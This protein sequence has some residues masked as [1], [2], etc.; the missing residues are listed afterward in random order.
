MITSPGTYCIPE[1][2]YH[3][4]PCPAPSLS[5]S[6]AKVL[7]R[8]SPLHAKMM[9]PKL[10]PNY[11]SP[12]SSRFDLGTMAHAMLLEGD[13]SKLVVIE[14]DDWRTKAAKEARDAARAEGKLPILQK[15][16][17]DLFAMV[18]QARKFL[19]NS[20]VGGVTFDSELTIAWQDNGVWCRSKYDWIS[21]RRDIVLD[22]KTTDDA[23]PETFI[24]QIGRMGYDM[25]AAFYTRGAQALGFRPTFAFLA[26]EITPPY[27]C[28][29]IALSNT[30]MEIAAGKADI[31][32]RT[33]AHC[34]K[35]DSWPAYTDRILYAEPPAWEMAKFQAGLED[36]TGAWHK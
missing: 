11:V 31:A 10:S 22:Y 6:L 21:D 23:N 2:E 27:A 19:K 16:S 1:A 12:E 34:L 9:H 25:Q 3:A 33:W 30:Y 4:D 35:A 18:Q 14:A 26:Q 8:Q 13:D 7:L 5:S 17:A 28:S 32:I 36:E 20:E 29:L 24:R 15:Q